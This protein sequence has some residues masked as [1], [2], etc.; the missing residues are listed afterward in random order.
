MTTQ[1]EALTLAL[2]EIKRV[3]EI[4][5]RE[6]GIGLC[7]EVVIAKLEEALAQP[8]QEPVGALLLGGIF[9]TSEGFE[10]EEWD[11]EWNHKAVESLQEKFV[12]NEPVTLSL[13]THPP[14]P[15]A[16]PEQEYKRGYADAMNW[17]VQNHLEHLPAA[18]PKQEPVAFPDAPQTI[19]LQVGDECPEDAKWKELVDVCWC[20]EQVFDNDIVYVRADTTPPQRKPLTDEHPLMVFAKECALGA[21]QEYELADA[22]NKAIEAADRII[23]ENT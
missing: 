22:A 11:I 5:L 3:K 14:V 9:Q 16:Q 8:E 2:D 19:Y 20:D 13:Y 18:Q 10:F 4:C 15:T 23:K 7:N 17:K 6:V 12:T 21:Y 1:T